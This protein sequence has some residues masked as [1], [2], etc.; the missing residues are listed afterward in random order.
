MAAVDPL[1][2]AANA[3]EQRLRLFFKQD[4]WDWY[5][6]PDPLTEKEFLSMTGVR[7]PLLALSW[8]QLNPGDKGGR[9]FSGKLGLRLTIAVKNQNG[10]K[11]RFLGDKAGP[12]L[13]PA[14]SGAIILLNGHT[15]EGLG[16]FFVT[17]CSQAYGDGFAD[18]NMAIATLDLTTEIT[19]GDITGDF[20]A[21]PDFLRGLSDF[22]LPG[23]PGTPEEPG[24]HFDVRTP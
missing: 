18:L 15:S 6:V 7:T 24:E 17:A 4:R 22:D 3:V 2:T 10:R 16:T 12:G 14:M 9:R 23:E 1:T 11:F 13:F 8:R 5:I 20:A 21:A 19:M